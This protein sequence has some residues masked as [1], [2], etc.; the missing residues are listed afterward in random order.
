MNTC[1][2]VVA[3]YGRAASAL[4]I[5]P[6]RIGV[7]TGCVIASPPAATA[8]NK[9]KEEKKNTKPQNIILPGNFNSMDYLHVDSCLLWIEM[10]QC[11]KG[12][13]RL[14]SV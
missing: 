8:S 1:I 10:Q 12:A 2:V 3:V 6:I 14:R 9:H 13:I 4:R 11:L 7:G 5:I